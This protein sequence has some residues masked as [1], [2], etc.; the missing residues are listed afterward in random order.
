MRN[1]LHVY[2]HDTYN[3]TVR[4]LGLMLDFI[5]GGKTNSSVSKAG[6]FKENEIKQA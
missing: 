5:K 2:S 4:V 6:H 3:I 1:F